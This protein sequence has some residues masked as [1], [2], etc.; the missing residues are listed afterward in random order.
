MR[1]MRA[2]TYSHGIRRAESSEQVDRR[3]AHRWNKMD[4]ALSWLP[5]LFAPAFAILT[6]AI[7]CRLGNTC[8]CVRSQFSLASNGLRGCG[9]AA[10]WRPVLHE[11]VTTFSL[12]G[13]GCAKFPGGRQA[14]ETCCGSSCGQRSRKIVLGI[15]FLSGSYRVA[16]R[17]ACLL[18]GLDCICWSPALQLDV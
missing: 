5:S 9:R 15:I 17:L 2:H 12:A 6:R 7:P 4:G 10:L 16:F 14:C 18:T 1:E 3:A 8:G 11:L 13:N